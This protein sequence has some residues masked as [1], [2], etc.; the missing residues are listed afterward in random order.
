MTGPASDGQVEIG[1]ERPLDLLRFATAGSVDDGKSTLIGRLLYET[2]QIFQDQLEHVQETSRRRGD[3][4]VDLALLTDGLRAEREQGITIDVAY[5]YFSTPRRK[6][7]IADTPGHE[8]YTRNMVTG[9]STADL[10]IVLVDA[11]K[12]VVEQSRRHAFIASLLRVP[13]VVFAVNKMD[14]VDYDEAVFERIDEEVSGWA[15]KLDFTDV[16]FIPIS[17]LHGDN[18]V[19]RSE[20]MPWYEGPSLLYHLEHVHIGSDRNL[21]DVRFPVQWVIRP[22]ADEHHDYR[23]YAGQVASGVLRPNDEVTVQPS[24]RQTRIHRIDSEGGKAIQEAFPPL[25]VTLLLEDDLDVSRGDMICRAHN[26]P[27]P[28]RELDAMVCW[29]SDAALRPRSR[30]AIKHTTRNARAIVDELRYRIDV[31]TLHRDE[32][33]SELGLNQIGRVHLRTSAPLLVDEYRRNRATGSFILIDEATN[34]TVGGGMILGVEP[35]EGDGGGES[36]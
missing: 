6:F 30:Y 9:A 18:V 14:L 36:P 11:R 27:I 31:N 13:H 17:A 3:S 21:I 20:R 34:D 19:E 33:A 26:H 10:A 29:M 25:S 24:G 23:G 12:G 28:T 32:E 7:I 4:Y 22:M 1:V 16:T 35:S 8:Q 5:R 2:K 15:N